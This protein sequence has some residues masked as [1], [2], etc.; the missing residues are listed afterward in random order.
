[1]TRSMRL[2]VCY[3][4]QHLPEER[5]ADD[6]RRMAQ[7]GLTRVRIGEFAWSRIEPAPG[8]FDWGWL[9]RA[10][11]T[12]HKAGHGIIIGTPTATPPK[13]LID[14]MPDMVAVDAA[15]RP[16]KFGSRRH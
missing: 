10:I 16:R 13:W 4:P 9:D 1:M 5:W 14:S 11:D 15:G 3:Y 7:M 2:G 8:H 6:A 12:L